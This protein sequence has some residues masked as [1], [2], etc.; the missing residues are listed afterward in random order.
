MK[1][2]ER[3]ARRF[4][5]KILAWYDKH[6]RKDLP[7]QKNLD[8]KKSAPYRVWL[9]EVMLQ[10]T[11]VATVIPYFERF[12]EEYPT[13]RDLANAS[14]DDVLHLWSGLGYYA[15]ARNLHA[16]AKYLVEKQ[17]GKFPD[18]VDAL[19]RLPG[20]GRSTAGAIASIAFRRRAA[21]LDGNVKRVLARHFAI[22]GIPVAGKAEKQFWE[23]AEALTPEVRIHD[24]TQAIMDMGAT[25]CTRSKP[26]CEECPLKKTCIAYQQ[27][28]QARFPEKKS[29]TKKIPVK[30]TRML[31]L[32][33]PQREVYLER[34]PPLGIWG[35]LWS[36]PELPL[37][38]DIKVWCKSRFGIVAKNIRPMEEIIHAFSHFHLQIYP[39]VVELS[40]DA[41]E[42]AVRDG[43]NDGLWCNIADGGI[44]KLRKGMAAPVSKLLALL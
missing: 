26:C 14:Q 43:R 30:Q 8:D 2:K 28:S 34:R 37:D 3:A 10:Q 20:V 44:R 29:K 38:Q 32:V 6:G 1:I 21:I 16:T 15:R 40:R 33:N 36:L 35:G 22:P 19:S 31:L 41:M 23:I 27:G 24:Y 17:D 18:N 39:L 7:W 11:Q 13:L 5:E 9:S 12:M 42:N 4:S 25:L